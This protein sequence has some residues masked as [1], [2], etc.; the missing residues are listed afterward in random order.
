MSY[1]LNCFVHAEIVCLFALT[2]KDTWVSL[3][4]NLL[5]L[6]TCMWMC[7]SPRYFAGVWGG[8]PPFCGSKGE[9]STSCSAAL[10]PVPQWTLLALGTVSQPAAYISPCLQ[11]YWGIINVHS[12]PIINAKL[13]LSWGLCLE[14]HSRDTSSYAA[15]SGHVCLWQNETVVYIRN[16]FTWVKAKQPSP[17]LTGINDSSI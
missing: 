8:N 9:P 14:N 13:H 5:I 11:P 10:Q 4:R 3:G 16:G 15:L 12:S 1:L 17:W 2:H 6:L 7:L